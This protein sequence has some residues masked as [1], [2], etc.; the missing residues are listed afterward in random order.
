MRIWSLHPGYLD[1]KGLVACWRETLLA[2]KVLD[3]RTAGYRNH[4]QLPRFR[5]LDDPL[6]A[7]GAYLDGLEAEAALRGYRFNRSLILRPHACPEETL[8]PVHAGQLDYE[9]DHLLAKL[10]IRD[11]ARHAVLADASGK[12]RPH[13]LFTVVPGGVEDWEVR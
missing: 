12:V 5:T 3:G 4:P 8:L 9:T 13:P 10:A 6:A 11:P 7:I 1:A 2:Q